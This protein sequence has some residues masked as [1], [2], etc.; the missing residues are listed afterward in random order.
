MHNTVGVA[1]ALEFT[2]ANPSRCR[3]AN[4]N[5]LGVAWA[6]QHNKG[7]STAALFFSGSL[8][9]E[10]V[11]ILIFSSGNFDCGAAKALYIWGLCTAELLPIEMFGGRGWIQ[12][13]AVYRKQPRQLPIGFLAHL[14]MKLELAMLKR[15][16]INFKSMSFRFFVDLQNVAFLA[17]LFLF[18]WNPLATC[19]NG[20]DFRILSIHNQSS[21]P[22]ASFTTDLFPRSL[23]T[24]ETEPCSYHIHEI[25]V[26]SPIEKLSC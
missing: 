1:T 9:V 13:H 12:K 8:R 23:P 2:S 6:L 24:H 26:E 11:C 10:H 15:A 19:Q 3:T 16:W 17:E 22:H 5:A 4:A 21:V 7:S 25:W 14:C 20:R 18:Q